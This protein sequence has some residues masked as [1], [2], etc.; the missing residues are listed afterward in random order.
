MHP[1]PDDICP[2]P[3]LPSASPTRPL[4]PPIDLAAVHQ[5]D[6]P[7]QA[8][9]ILDGREQ[10]YVY[11]RDGAPNADLLAAK[12]RELHGAERAIVCG[13]GMAALS[14]AVLALVGQGDHVVASNRLYGQ[15]LN[16]LTNEAPRLG[17]RTTLVD[18]CDLK[19][20]AAAVTPGTRLLIAE[21]I[22]NPTLRV[23]DIE[24]LAGIAHRAEA[25][26]LIDN[27]FACPTVC[28]PLEHD[29]DLV[30]ESLTKIMNGHSDV[31]LGVLCGR[32]ELWPRI[33][34]V[35]S[36]WGLSAPA[37]DSWL[38]ARGLGTL[39]LRADRADENARVVAAFLLKKT[40]LVEA[41]SYPGLPQHPDYAL[42]RRQFGERFGSM[43]AFTL[44]GGTE[45][46]K[47]FIGATSGSQR[48]RIPFSPSLGDLSTTLSHPASTSHRK[49]A[50][51]AQAA[52]GITGGTIRLSVGIESAATILAALEEGLATAT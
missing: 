34:G 36:A 6:G 45:A 1:R 32:E 41:V 42:A 17:I 14:A 29:A 35:V 39:A 24:A 47:R 19:A 5:C 30:L 2:R 46:A 13:S 12:C 28:R 27:T 23:S 51:D 4:V 31:L 8:A 18:T 50:A 15:S 25:K 7:E 52:L 37:F 48:A 11:R 16:L 33:P 38:A 26:L 20:T 49:L 10:G 44:R 3:E 22:T 9:A 40:E 21:T 43:V